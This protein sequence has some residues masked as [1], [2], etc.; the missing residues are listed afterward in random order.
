M[1]TD[2]RKPQPNEPRDKDEELIRGTGDQ[3]EDDFDEEDDDSEDL[4]DD[5]ETDQTI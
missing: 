3:D 4:D 1:P 5:E 2:E